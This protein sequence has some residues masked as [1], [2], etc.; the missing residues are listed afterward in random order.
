MNSDEEKSKQFRISPVRWAL[1]RCYGNAEETCITL[2][3]FFITIMGH[4]PLLP[5][6]AV[7]RACVR[8]V[9]G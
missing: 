8:H 9:K 7:A 6:R 3:N 1:T 5:H 4:H 2:L